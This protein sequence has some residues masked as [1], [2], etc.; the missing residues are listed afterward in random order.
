VTRCTTGSSAAGVA[1]RISRRESAVD[2]ALAQIGIDTADPEAFGFVVGIE[3]GLPLMAT[4]GVHYA[5][6]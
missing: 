6:Y 4:E 3:P 1:G 5:L 2:S